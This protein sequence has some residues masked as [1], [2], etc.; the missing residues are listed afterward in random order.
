MLGEDY[1][2]LL[3]SLIQTLPERIALPAEL[4]G[5]F[6]ESGPQ[7]S[8]ENDQRSGARNRVRT[9]GLLVLESWYPSMDRRPEL[10]TIF[11]KDFSKTGVGFLAP[12]TVF[13]PARSSRCSWPRFGFASRF[14][15][16]DEWTRI[17][18]TTAA[19]SWNDTTPTR[20]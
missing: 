11:T 6:E 5:F 17:V 7:Q 20:W 18:S 10:M 3:G 8:Y 4:E 12:R 9:R 16:V 15:A 14:D 2:R 13:F 1:P 19:R